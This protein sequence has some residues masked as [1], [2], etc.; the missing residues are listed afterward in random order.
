MV[1]ILLGIFIIA[2]IFA[3]RKDYMAYKERYSDKITLY[4]YVG[5]IALVV[6]TALIILFK[7]FL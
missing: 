1:P 5:V 6:A 7:K 3:Y 2:L 4:T